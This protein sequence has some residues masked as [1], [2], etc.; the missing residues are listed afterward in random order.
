MFSAACPFR[1]RESS[2]PNTTSKT[3][4][5][6]FSIDQWERI[7]QILEMLDDRQQVGMPKTVASG[8]RVCSSLGHLVALHN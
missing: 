7:R 6:L 4:C 1:I 2:S 8:W 5:R 3:Q